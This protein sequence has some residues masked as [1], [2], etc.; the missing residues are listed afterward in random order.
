M[1][2]KLRNEICTKLCTGELILVV[3]YAL[4]DTL[5]NSS[6]NYEEH[7]HMETEHHIGSACA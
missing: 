3:G 7:V 6:G 4:V 1:H 5:M 2:T